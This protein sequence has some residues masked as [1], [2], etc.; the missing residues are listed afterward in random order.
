MYHDDPRVSIGERSKKNKARDD[1]D[2]VSPKICFAMAYQQN[3]TANNKHE[4][5]RESITN[6]H[7]SPKKSGFYF[8]F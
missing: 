2:D 6:V 5:H 4:G 1:R 3:G 7:R 8:K